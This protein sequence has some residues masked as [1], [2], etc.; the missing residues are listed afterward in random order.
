MAILFFKCSTEQANNY[1]MVN[2][3]LVSIIIIIIIMELCTDL[4]SSCHTAHGAQY[5]AVFM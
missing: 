2:R 4:S 3:M 1:S 5:V